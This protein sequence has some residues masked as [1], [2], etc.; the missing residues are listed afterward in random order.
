M[1]YNV[2]MGTLTPTHSLSA[3]DWLERLVSEMTYNVLMGTL[4]PTHSLSASDWLERL[5]SEMTYNV[6]MGTLNP[7]HSL[8]HFSVCQLSVDVQVINWTLLH[9]RQD[10]L[11]ESDMLT[12]TVVWCRV[13]LG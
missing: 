5:V 13:W 4:N 6:L 10:C 12:D 2:L 11:S 9:D 3:S 1:T 7:T 8:T